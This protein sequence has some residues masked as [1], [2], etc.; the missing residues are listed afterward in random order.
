MNVLVVDHDFVSCDS[1]SNAFIALG[2]TVIAAAS[3]DRALQILRAEPGIAVMFIRVELPG[4]GGTLLAALARR[5]R[6]RLVIALT[7]SQPTV[8]VP[9]MYRFVPTP[10][11]P[12][13]LAE[14]MGQ[15]AEPTIAVAGAALQ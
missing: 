1:V 11:R 2:A 4:M 13:M 3:G 5:I 15:A 6:P 12:S 14:L 8:T 10:W 9:P 7:S